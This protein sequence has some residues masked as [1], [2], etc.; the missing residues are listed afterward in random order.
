MALTGT[1]T[2]DIKHE[3]SAEHVSPRTDAEADARYESIASFSDYI[4]SFLP[5]ALEERI[6]SRLYG[7]S[8][9]YMSN[10]TMRE[11][12]KKL[13]AMV[14]DYPERGKAKLLRSKLMWLVG[15]MYGATDDELL[16]PAI[17]IELSQNA[18][19]VADDIE[20]GALLRRGEKALQRKYGTNNAINVS[21]YLNKE[22]WI[23]LSEYSKK[24][25][26]ENGRLVREVF[27]RYAD[28]TLYGQTMELEFSDLETLTF[29]TCGMLLACKTA[30]YSAAAPAVAGAI[31]GGKRQGALDALETIGI[32]VGMSFQLRDDISDI[33]EDVYKG[34]PT[35][36]I[37]KA[38]QD[39]SPKEKERLRSIYSEVN[40]RRKDGYLDARL[41][42][43]DF[44]YVMGLMK[45]Y[46]GAG[47]AEQW[48]EKYFDGAKELYFGSR[49]II[50][51]NKYSELIIG[52]L[53]E[54]A[55]GK[56]LP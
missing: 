53:Y 30:G 8:E 23:A 17:A 51:D 7:S 28:Q 25:G 36:L 52:L 5:Q 4:N 40:E 9:E 14:A 45:K 48:R 42:E 15:K 41:S 27:D 49:D 2:R 13:E 18:V 31:I 54:Y 35:L 22:V 10:G 6:H 3:E 29:D 16:L 46:D 50:P 20:D 33:E 37:Y 43:P 21:L 32:L 34:T 24:Y 38:Y 39:A 12:I 56:P 11:T 47:Y 55:S 26:E 44:N 19:L 1:K